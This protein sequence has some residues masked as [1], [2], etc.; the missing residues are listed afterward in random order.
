M[1]A[2]GFACFKNLF[3]IINEKLKR[4]TKVGSSGSGSSGASNMVSYGTSS[5]GGTV[6][7]SYSYNYEDSGKD[8]KDKKDGSGSSDFDYRV[9]V[10]P[11]ELE[12]IKNL[13]T[14]IHQSQIEEAAE[15]AIE[16]LNKLY[17]NVDSELDKKAIEVRT[18][19][20]TTAFDSLR[21]IVGQKSTLDPKIFE[22]KCQRSL[23]L[24]RSMMDESEKKGIG[25]LKAH[26]GLVKG[27]LM[28]FTVNN[29]ITS[30]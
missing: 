4:I 21:T 1:T 23:D 19:Y 29:D 22:E 16:F 30:G 12:G 14:F 18:E 27:E 17:F 8:S 3:L 24:I 28:T 5:Y 13:W 2:D 26:S 10:F 25:A 7:A 15:R 20:L 9:N 11:G 6:Y